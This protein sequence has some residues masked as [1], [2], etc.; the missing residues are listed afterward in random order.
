MG[1]GYKV[2]AGAFEAGQRVTVH[3]AVWTLGPLGGLS[4]G[5]RESS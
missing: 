1:K 2:A 5:S 3:L 4:L